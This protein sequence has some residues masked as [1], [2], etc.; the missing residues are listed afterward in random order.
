MKLSE[1]PMWFDDKLI[2]KTTHSADSALSVVQAAKHAE[3]GHKG[4]MRHVG[5]VPGA[6]IAQWLKEAGVKWNDIAARDEVIK[7]KMLSGEFAAFRNWE[8]RY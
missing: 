1:K 2:I 4:D 5:R 8:G 6:L 7:R 3:V